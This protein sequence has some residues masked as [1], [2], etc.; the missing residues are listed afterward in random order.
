MHLN[1]I[2]YFVF[3]VITQRI[4]LRQVQSGSRSTVDIVRKRQHISYRIRDFHETSMRLLGTDQV[5]QR[6]GKPNSFDRDGYVSDD[7]R[8]PTQTQC[9][10]DMDAPEN[11]SLIF[12]SSLSGQQT[13]ECNSLRD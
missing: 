13:T 2:S 6:I 7:L 12:P 11:M 10:P 4:R 8:D 5:L 3:N 9:Q 1:P